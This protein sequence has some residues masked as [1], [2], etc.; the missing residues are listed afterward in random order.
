VSEAVAIE[1]EERRITQPLALTLLAL[2]FVT[3]VVDALSFLG[4]G[5]VFAGMM[6]G[7]VLFLGFGIAGASGSSVVAP[8]VAIV[9]FAAG[10]LAGGFLAARSPDRPGRGLI[11]CMVFEVLLVG[12]AAVLAAAIDVTPDE[13]SAWVLIAA[14]SLAMGARNT[15]VRRIGLAELP[16]NVLTVAVASFEAG[17]SFAGA[18]PSHLV[19]RAASVLAMLG[20]AIAGALLLEG[21]GLSASLA[22]A[23]IFTGLAA[24]AYAF[25]VRQAGARLPL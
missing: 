16:T 17:T 25:V 21:P 23:A 20:G 6:T 24:T 8:L 12:A 19:P 4:L 1:P 5:Q 22:F 7:N 9:A 13:L 15:A 11:A 18:S 14:L 2:T 10:G 3:G